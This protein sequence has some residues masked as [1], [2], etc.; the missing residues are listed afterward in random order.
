MHVHFPT[1]GA[2]VVARQ[3]GYAHICVNRSDYG[4]PD[5]DCHKGQHR[6]KG[7]GFVIVVF[8]IINYN[9]LLN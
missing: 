7:T 8:V 2:N 1:G 5:P 4:G 9:L 6:G 3:A